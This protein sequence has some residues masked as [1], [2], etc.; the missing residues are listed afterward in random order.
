MTFSRYAQSIFVWQRQRGPASY[1][2]CL[3]DLKRKRP[4]FESIEIVRNGL[5]KDSLVGERLNYFANRI[6]TLV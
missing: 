1:G 4:T 2:K 3:P 6:F 5:G